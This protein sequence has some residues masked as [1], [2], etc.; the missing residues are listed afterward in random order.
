MAVDRN[1]N[2]TSRGLRGAS[3]TSHGAM[4]ARIDISGRGGGTDDYRGL[5]NK[6]SINGVELFGNKTNEELHI[7]TDTNELTNGAGFIDNTVDNL[8]NYYLKSETYTRSEVEQLIAAIQQCSFE[9]VEQLPLVG[10][11]NIIYLVP[12][13]TA[14]TRNIYDEYIYVNRFYFRN[15]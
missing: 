13:Q 4:T 11:T 8:I 5:S 12:K 7:P 10:E 9:I 6:P 1:I 2:M 3:V 14:E 15:M